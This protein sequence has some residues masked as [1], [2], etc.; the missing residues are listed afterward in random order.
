[1]PLMWVIFVVVGIG[2]FIL[3]SVFRK[4]EEERQKN[5]PRPGADANR[6][7]GRKPAT[8]LDRFLE[9]KEK[10]KE[11]KVNVDTLTLTAPWAMPVEKAQ[12]R[13]PRSVRREPAEQRPPARQ[14]QGDRPPAFV[15]SVRRSASDQRTD[16][17]PV[18]PPLIAPAPKPAL[19]PV[20]LELVPDDEPTPAIGLTAGMQTAPPPLALG[21]VLSRPASTVSPVLKLV[22]GLLRDPKALG[23]AF[24]LREI[25]GPPLCRRHSLPTNALPPRS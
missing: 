18:R 6:N 25:F 10:L 11:L 3:V 22:P 23:A 24:A 2:V 7:A 13:K 12:A 5:L 17:A 15:P 8:D 19:A 16:L 20:V 14:R 9:E 21:G 1:M 4:A